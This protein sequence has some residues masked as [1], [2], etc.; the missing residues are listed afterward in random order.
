M[1]LSDWWILYTVY[2][3]IYTSILNKSLLT[4]VRLV[5][6]SECSAHK[7][8]LMQLTYCWIPDR[9]KWIETMVIRFDSIKNAA[10][11]LAKANC[12]RLSE[13]ARASCNAWVKTLK[14]DRVRQQSPTVI[15][16]QPG[17]EVTLSRITEDN[18]MHIWCN[19]SKLKELLLD[20]LEQS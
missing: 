18:L 10:R 16:H 8:K 2:I 5:R 12:R 9:V 4:L 3:Y 7:I 13:T 11:D 1:N 19:F 15:S 14:R 20:Q 17:N 6:W